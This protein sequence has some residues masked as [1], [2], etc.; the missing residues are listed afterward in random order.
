[1]DNMNT[2]ESKPQFVIKNFK[3]SIIKISTVPR[4]ENGKNY[5]TNSANDLATAAT[6]M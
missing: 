6:I 1:M 3:L 4:N 2:A 5:I